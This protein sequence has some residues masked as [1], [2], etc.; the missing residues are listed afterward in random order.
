[1]NSPAL[2]IV[3]P[4]RNRADCARATIESLLLI[5]GDVQVVVHDNSSGDELELWYRSRAPDH[6]LVYARE[7]AQLSFVENF[8]RAVALATGDYVCII[9]DDDTVHREIIRVVSWASEHRLD[10]VVLLPVCTYI[11]PGAGAGSKII[12]AAETGLLTVVPFLSQLEVAR[13]RLNQ[14]RAFLGQLLDATRDTTLA[15]LLPPADR[16]PKTTGL[17]IAGES[18]AIRL[19][20][21]QAQVMDIIAAQAVKPRSSRNLQTRERHTLKLVGVQ[22]QLSATIEQ[23]QKILLEIESHRPILLVDALHLTPSSSLGIDDDRGLLEARLD[24][25]AIEPRQKA[26]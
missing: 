26:P 15:E 6:R 3:V 23:L 21:L 18:E 4:T 20:S 14:E 8:E 2:S 5:D 10:A 1:M 9:G 19:A 17:F 7:A 13:A 16:T 25:V 11:W 24:V 22:V 12:P